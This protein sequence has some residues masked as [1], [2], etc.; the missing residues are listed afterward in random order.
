M[1]VTIPESAFYIGLTIF[2]IG[3]QVYH[4]FQI[5]KIQKEIHKLWEH[6]ATVAV[7]M[8]TRTEDLDKKLKDK[9]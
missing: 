2:L 9:E 7:V 8:F 1:T 5:R 6:A 3:M 4:Q